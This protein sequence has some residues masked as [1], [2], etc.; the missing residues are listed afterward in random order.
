M[1]YSS[2]VANFTGNHS[3]TKEFFNSRICTEKPHKTKSTSC[4]KFLTSIIMQKNTRFYAEGAMYFAEMFSTN[5]SYQREHD[6]IEKNSNFWNFY[7]YTFSWFLLFCSNCFPSGKHIIEKSK[8]SCSSF[9][10]NFTGYLSSTKEFLNSKSCKGKP[11][12]TK[13]TSCSIFMTSIF[14]NAKKTL[15]YAEGAID[16]AEM[17][18]TTYSYQWEHDCIEKNSN[19]WNFYFHIFL[20]FFL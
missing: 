8:M 9:V 5:Y 12:K 18:S 1:S 10:E 2:F 19:F 15:F 6:C 16:F 7:F 20:C 17:C 13:S 14:T 4:S 11:H 3:S